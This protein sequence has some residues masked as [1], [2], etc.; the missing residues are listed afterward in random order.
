[1]KTLRRLRNEVE[2]MRAKNDPAQDFEHVKR[3]YSNA[4]NLCKTEKV[5][6]KLVLTASLLHDIVSF[7]KSDKRAQNASN[8]SAIKASKI[9]Q[10]S[11]F[12][13]HPSIQLHP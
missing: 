11:W 8:K 5:D 7:P 6:K 12:H 4:E 1:M 2:K 10:N 13:P 9:L 3:V